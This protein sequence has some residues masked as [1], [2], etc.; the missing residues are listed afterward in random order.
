MSQNTSNLS[1][2]SNQAKLQQQTQQ[3]STTNQAKV[4]VPDM[5]PTASKLI[6]EVVTLMRQI[7]V[8]LE[9]LRWEQH[10]IA[11]PLQK[12]PLLVLDS[13]QRE[14]KMAIDWAD[15]RLNVMITILFSFLLICW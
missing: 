4:V 13:E 12:E 6:E 2:T 5:T 11:V 3:T 15:K 10:Q 8:Q 7:N 9:K 1:D 14:T